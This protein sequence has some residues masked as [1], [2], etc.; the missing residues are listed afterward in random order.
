MLRW[1]VDHACVE[2]P[3]L[4]RSWPRL[5]MG[6]WFLVYLLSV[7]MLLRYRDTVV[8]LVN[9]SE[10][11]RCAVVYITCYCDVACSVQSVAIV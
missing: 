6:P 1:R 3:G 10:G 11:D 7:L 9:R 4:E 5:R 2:L 8:N